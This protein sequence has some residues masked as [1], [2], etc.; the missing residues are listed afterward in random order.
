MMSM[1]YKFV[2]QDSSVI[3]DSPKDKQEEKG[4]TSKEM[5]GVV[6]DMSMNADLE[7]TRLI[8]GGT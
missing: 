3:V 8:E 4:L 7:R 5:E 1:I 2:I 6:G